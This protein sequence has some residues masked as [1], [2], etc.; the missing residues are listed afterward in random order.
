[1]SKE[2]KVTIRIDMEGD[3]AKYFLYIKKVKGMM[4]NSEVVRLL[5]AEEYRRI[6]G[7]PPLR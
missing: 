1:M 6:A 7:A 5:I 2:E 4:N 3:L